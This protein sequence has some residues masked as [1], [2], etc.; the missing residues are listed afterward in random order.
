MQTQ[1]LILSQKKI[2][3]VTHYIYTSI[4]FTSNIHTSRSCRISLESSSFIRLVPLQKSYLREMQRCKD[5]ISP[6]RVYRRITQGKWTHAAR[7]LGYEFLGLLPVL[8]PLEFFLN[9]G[10]VWYTR[11]KLDLSQKKSRNYTLLFEM[12]AHTQKMPYLCIVKRIIKH[13]AI[14]IQ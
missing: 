9:R 5:W 12:F 7:P 2:L 8:Q 4:P 3:F 6:L 11:V 13:Y 1:M 10:G 14:Y